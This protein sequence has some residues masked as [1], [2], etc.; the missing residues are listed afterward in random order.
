[1]EREE[2]R[3]EV[4]V[5]RGESGKKSGAQGIWEAGTGEGRGGREEGGR[6]ERKTESGWTEARRGSESEAG[7]PP[8][9]RLPAIR[10]HRRSGQCTSALREV[11]P[12]RHPGSTAKDCPA[13][14]ACAGHGR[15]CGPGVGS[16]GRASAAGGRPGSRGRPGPGT[17]SRSGSRTSTGPGTSS[18]IGC[19]STSPGS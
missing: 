1:M 15:P 5:E 6:W 11:V 19:S 7:R 8:V 4:V 18:R 12:P 14:P 3:V 17:S 9:P 2:R 13:A 10:R 16:S